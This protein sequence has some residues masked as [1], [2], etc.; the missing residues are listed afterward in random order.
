MAAAQLDELKQIAS[1]FQTAYSSTP[2]KLK[3]LDAFSACAL[4]TAVLQARLGGAAVH[5]VG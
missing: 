3:L 1:S 4:A 2:T 5:V